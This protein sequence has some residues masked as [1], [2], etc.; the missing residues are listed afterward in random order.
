M[1]SPPELVNDTDP[2]LATPKLFVD[3]RRPDDEYV[4]TAVPDPL[5]ACLITTEP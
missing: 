3:V 4:E 1:P 5:S 2:V